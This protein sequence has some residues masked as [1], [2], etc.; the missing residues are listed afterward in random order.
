M[1]YDR[2]IIKM[3]PG[4]VNEINSQLYEVGYSR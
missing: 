4:K 1:T 3:D 2:E